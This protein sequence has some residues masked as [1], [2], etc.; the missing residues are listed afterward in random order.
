MSQLGWIAGVGI[1]LL[2]SAVSF[3]TANLLADCYRSP[4]PVTGKRKYSYME[5]V[6]ATLGI[7]SLRPKA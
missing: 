6:K 2:F 5:A 1:L 7:P 3:Y 4:D